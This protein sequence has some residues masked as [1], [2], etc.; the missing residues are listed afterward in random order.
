MAAAIERESAR[1]PAMGQARGEQ[2][3]RTAGTVQRWSSLAPRRG[4]NCCPGEPEPRSRASCIAQS[5]CQ[6][7]QPASPEVP[8]MSPCP[9]T[10]PPAPPGTLGPQP[11][12]TGTTLGSAPPKTRTWQVGGCPPSCAPAT[13][14]TGASAL[15]AVMHCS[16]VQ[17]AVR[18]AEYG[19]PSA[20]RHR[21]RPTNAG[22]PSELTFCSRISAARASW[23]TVVRP[24]RQASR[25]QSSRIRT[26][27]TWPHVS[28]A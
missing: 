24:V 18:K 2:A 27:E 22:M 15:R 8:L 21:P 19:R 12:T 25:M 1:T 28:S 26:S 4:L 10:A 14:A 20:S 9:P 11:P 16:S 6:H 23:E 5:S 7:F 3:K 13:P 17:R